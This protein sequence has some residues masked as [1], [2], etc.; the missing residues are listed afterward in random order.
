MIISAGVIVVRRESGVWKFLLLRAY[1]NWDFPKGE[2]EAGESPLDTAIRETREETGITELNFR[3][4]N[5]CR[6]TEPYKHGTKIARYFL[7]ETSQTAVIFAIN[8]Q[9][10]GPE[11]HEY[12]WADATELRKLIPP[13]LVPVVKWAT[14]VVEP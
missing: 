5:V 7:A 14:G 13:R 3:W 12:R 2:V 8:P 6:E 10:G 4:G 1:R 11:H 9:I